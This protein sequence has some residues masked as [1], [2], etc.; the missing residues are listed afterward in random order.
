MKLA[1][2]ITLISTL[3]RPLL[4]ITLIAKILIIYVKHF[5]LIIKYLTRFRNLLMNSSLLRKISKF[6]VIKVYLYLKGLLR[7]VDVLVIMRFLPPTLL[8][9]WLTHYLVVDVQILQ[10]DMLSSLSFDHNAVGSALDSTYVDI[11]SL[12]KTN[13]DSQSKE[14]KKDK[15]DELNFNLVIL[16]L[17]VWG[18]ASIVGIALEWDQIAVL[19]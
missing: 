6:S 16:L 1:G 13:L 3:L 17:V 10:C 18:V 12:E 2:L 8:L 11:A 4:A 9:L 5:T 15:Q 19:I 14:V 7:S